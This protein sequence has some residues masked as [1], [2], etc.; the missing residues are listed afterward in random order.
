MFIGQVVNSAGKSLLELAGAG[1]GT[2]GGIGS[3][4][5]GFN[6]ISFAAG[7]QWSIE[8]DAAGFGPGKTIM[9][10]AQGI[11]SCWTGSAPVPIFT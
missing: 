9:G 10:F 3:Q 4:I 8:G 6:E 2:L 5:T 11:R 1:F 7:P